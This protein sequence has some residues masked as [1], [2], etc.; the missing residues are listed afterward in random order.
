MSVS[1]SILLSVICLG[2]VFVGGWYLQSSLMELNTQVMEQ[3]YHN[4]EHTKQIEE[5]NKQVIKQ[6]D[7]ITQQQSQL[8]QLNV[9][10]K[11]LFNNNEK[12][13]REQK[14]TNNVTSSS[15]INSTKIIMRQLIISV[16]MEY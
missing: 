4:Q 10:I 2:V 15:F 1:I 9:I 7:Q 14:I 8:Q 16:I 13:S 3:Y 12:V 5:L 6:N 11:V